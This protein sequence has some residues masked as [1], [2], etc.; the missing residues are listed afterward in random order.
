M[1]I[2]LGPDMSNILLLLHKVK[3]NSIFLGYG[4][5][6]MRDIVCFSFLPPGLNLSPI[7]PMCYAALRLQ[8]LPQCSTHA[9]ST[10]LDHAGLWT[11]FR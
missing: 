9:K 2:L 8:S 6:M 4:L 1:P 3:S 11:G 7:M 10:V 5:L